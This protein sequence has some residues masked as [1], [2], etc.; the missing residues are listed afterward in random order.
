MNLKETLAHLKNWYLTGS[1]YSEKLLLENQPKDNCVKIKDLSSELFYPIFPKSLSRVSKDVY[2]ALSYLFTEDQTYEGDFSKWFFSDFKMNSRVIPNPNIPTPGFVLGLFRYYYRANKLYSFVTIKKNFNSEMIKV[3]GNSIFDLKDIDYLLY[4]TVR[5]ENYFVPKYFNEIFSDGKNEV[6]KI[7][8]YSI[9]DFKHI[10]PEK[11]RQIIDDLFLL[12]EDSSVKI[13]VKN[14]DW[15]VNPFAEH[16]YEK[17]RK[18]FTQLIE[19][20]S[21]RD[22]V[23][24]A[25]LLRYSLK[26]VGLTIET[27]ELKGELAEALQALKINRIPY[28][29]V[30]LIDQEKPFYLEQQ[31]ED[32]Y[33]KIKV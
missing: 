6:T 29:Y 28:S 15:F 23:R 27:S 11:Y 2:E 21:Y 7:P 14:S 33:A 26:F 22:Y 5:D 32:N 3:I 31:K 4:G 1:S 8:G 17:E 25:K 24:M 30:P 19:A 18:I 20:V 12:P 13:E 9:H 16:D 10:Y